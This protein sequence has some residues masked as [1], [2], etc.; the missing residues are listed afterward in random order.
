[1]GIINQIGNVKLENIAVLEIRNMENNAFTINFENNYVS[2]NVGGKY[3][4]DH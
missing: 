3:L 4:C 2:I 1:M